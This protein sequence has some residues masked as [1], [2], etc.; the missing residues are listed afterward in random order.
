MSAE[1][2]VAPESGD[3]ARREF[4]LRLP[5]ELHERLRRRAFEDRAHMS[6]LVRRAVVEFLDRGQ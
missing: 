4:T 3:L 5:P 6:E 1:P 2:T